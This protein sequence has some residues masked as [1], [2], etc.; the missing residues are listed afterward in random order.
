MLILRCQRLQVLVGANIRPPRH[1]FVKVKEGWQLLTTVLL[2]N[3]NTEYP[4][5]L[6]VRQPSV[7]HTTVGILSL[8]TESVANY[9]IT[10]RIINVKVYIKKVIIE[11]MYNEKDT[12]PKAPWPER[13]VPPPLT[14]GIRATALPVPQ[15]SALVWWP[16]IHHIK[17]KFPLNIIIL[18]TFYNYEFKT[19]VWSHLPV[20]WLHR[21]GGCSC[22]CWYARS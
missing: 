12:F 13:W 19:N 7:Q 22:A 1:I 4:L 16:E 14:R 15:D 18:K 6:F 2:H 11:S 5:R 9:T 8:V 10:A 3:S 20:H 17:V 21:A